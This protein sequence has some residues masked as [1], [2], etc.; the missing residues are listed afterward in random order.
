MREPQMAVE[1]I[2]AK[3]HLVAFR[4]DVYAV[5]RTVLAAH[6]GLRLFT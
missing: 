5:M 2:V 3:V 4:T 1:A 6:E